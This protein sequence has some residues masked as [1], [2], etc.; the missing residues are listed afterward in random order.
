M[1]CF[2]AAKIRFGT[3]A[4]DQLGH[5]EAPEEYLHFL[6]VVF[7]AVNRDGLNLRIT[8]VCGGTK[9]LSWRCLQTVD[10]LLHYEDIA[11]FLAKLYFFNC[12]AAEI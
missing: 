11:F 7:L 1:L 6:V 5:F 9:D 8:P 4:I 10:E 2:T 12:V 3:L